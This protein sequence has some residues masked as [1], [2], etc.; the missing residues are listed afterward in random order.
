MVS[1]T[2]NRT[3]NSRG[4]AW[5]WGHTIIASGKA[6]FGTLGS[7]LSWAERLQESPVVRIVCVHGSSGNWGI[8]LFTFSSQE[9]NSLNYNLTSSGERRSQ[10]YVLHSFS[11]HHLGF[12]C[13]RRE[14]LTLDTAAQYCHLQMSSAKSLAILGCI[15]PAP[16]RVAY[17]SLF[18]CTFF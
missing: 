16:A 3:H 5:A 7:I 12:L 4:R 14:S 11:V 10:D 2:Q 18:S 6:Q 1:H 15:W 8:L 17:D 9:K 13:P